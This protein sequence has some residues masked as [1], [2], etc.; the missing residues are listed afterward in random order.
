MPAMATQAKRV[1]G[2][3]SAAD[4]LAARRESLL[5]AGLELFGAA[6]DTAPTVRAVCAEAKLTARYFY[7]SFDDL[8]AL[9]IAVFERVVGEAAQAILAALAT[10]PNDAR[11]RA[12][13]VIEAFVVNLTDDPR[14]ARVA[15]TVAP[16][17]PD[18]E[19][20]RMATVRMFSRLTAQEGG[21]FYG[22][23]E[24]DDPDPIVEM[25]ASLLVGGLAH[26]MLAWLDGQLAVQR[27]QLVDYCAEIFVVTG[28]RAAE[29]AAEQRG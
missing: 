14:R 27:D 28:A 6:G 2:G 3:E 13:T 18:L 7:E 22:A 15:F 17:N 19:Q 1:Y 16:G 5:A 24:T 10:A 26:L 23:P 11:G 12:H 9:R 20:R 29:I 25:T 8:D 21:A 4:R